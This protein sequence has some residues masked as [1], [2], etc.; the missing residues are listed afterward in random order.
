M[1]D[2]IS[3]ALMIR[4]SSPKSK[5]PTINKTAVCWIAALGAVFGQA[6]NGLAETPSNSKAPVAFVYVSYTPSGG[7]ANKIAAYAADVNGKLSWVPGSTFVVN[8]STMAVNGKYL[9]ASNLAGVYVAGFRI[10]PNGALHWVN[11]TDVAQFDPSG[12][13]YATPLV[14]DHTGATLYREEDV[15]GL[16]EEAEYQS[17]TIDIPTGKLKYIGKSGQQFLFNTP[18]SFSGNNKFAYGS[19]CI[20]YQGGIWIHSRDW[21][22]RMTV[23]WITE[24][25]RFP[26]LLLR[27][28]AT[29]TAVPTR[30]PI[31]P[32]TS[33]SRC[34]PSIPTFSR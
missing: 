12:C 3:E 22:G 21:C 34:R 7:A 17:F 25:S 15:G 20:D 9:F 27:T 30:Q 2:N 1:R 29:T 28:P 32:T 18:L 24:A 8:V 10:Q 33:R 5:S 16:C 26:R 23:C 6:S 4:L 19:D 31:R 11:S 14:L 13:F